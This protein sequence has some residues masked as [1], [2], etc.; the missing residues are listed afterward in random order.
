MDQQLDANQWVDR[1]GDLMF[2]YTL[3][4]VKDTDA[5]EEI[6]QTALIAALQA[7]KSYEGRSSE[8]S[9]LFGILKHK[10]LDHFRDI[11]Q[12]RSY[13]A[14]SDDDQDPYEKDYKIDGHW[15]TPRKTG[16]P[17]LNGRPLTAS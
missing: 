16:T 4:R 1:Y 9:W 15:V 5:A 10:I 14:Q 17:T 13:E 6:V 3:V 12:K 8:K 11:K 7:R 2:R